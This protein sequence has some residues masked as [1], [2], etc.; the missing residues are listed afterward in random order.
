MNTTEL[1]RYGK[2]G[3]NTLVDSITFFYRHVSL[4]IISLIPAGIR[5]Y[6]MW[7]ELKT[8]FWLEVIVEIARLFLC[9][10]M[11]AYLT[12]ANWQTMR[13]KRFWKQLA[14]TCSFHLQKH[15]PHVFLAQ[16]AVFF[17]C[18]YAIGNLAVTMVVQ[19]SLV[20]I[21]NL[22]N[23]AATEHALEAGHNAYVFFLKNMSIIPLTIVYMLN[24][25]G[26]GKAVDEHDERSESKI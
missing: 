16:I 23:I 3:L 10:V 12:N 2:T 1:L 13:K 18:L 9:L 26:V 6:Q 24:M 15:W 22:L 14:T 11:I 25:F 21:L 20:P 7:N 17:I 8:P 19:L 5:L 4:L